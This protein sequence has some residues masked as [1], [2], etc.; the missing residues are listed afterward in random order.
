MEACDVAQEPHDT[1]DN[2]PYDSDS[3]YI[4]IEWRYCGCVHKRCWTT[5]TNCASVGS[6]KKGSISLRNKEQ[7]AVPN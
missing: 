1:E 3:D 7:A 4:N 6:P 2:R 5:R